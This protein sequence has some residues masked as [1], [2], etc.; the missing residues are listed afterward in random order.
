MALGDAYV[1]LPDLKEYLKIYDGNIESDDNLQSAIDSASGEIGKI[2]NRQ[3]QRTETATA[4]IYSPNRNRTYVLTDD[5]WITTGLVVEYDNT[6]NGDWVALSATDYELLPLNGV[7][8]G[9]DGWPYNRIELTGNTLCQFPWVR[10]RGSVRVTAKWGWEAVPAAVR[11]A[12]LIIAA[13]THQLK[14]AP[15]GV[16]GMDQFGSVMR[17]RENRIALGKLARYTRNRYLVG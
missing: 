5:F 6:G 4:R 14:D 13:E 3:F 16:A 2:C 12:C 15:F 8:D 9:E 11:Q 10:R 17:V 1:E 7:V